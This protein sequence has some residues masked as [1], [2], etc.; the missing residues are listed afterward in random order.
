LIISRAKKMPQKL[1]HVAQKI[2]FTVQ[3]IKKERQEPKVHG[4]MQGKCS[5]IRD[6]VSQT[7]E[8][9]KTLG[10]NVQL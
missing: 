4:E 6:A 2:F 7:V 3:I 9:K 1:I 5:G 8:V 10:C